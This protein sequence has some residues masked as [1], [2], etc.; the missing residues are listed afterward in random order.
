MYSSI[1]FEVYVTGVIYI[2]S[3]AL[4]HYIVNVWAS[5]FI[6]PVKYIIVRG[7]FYCPIYGLFFE[8]QIS[9]LQERCVHPMEE[10]YYLYFNL[11][12]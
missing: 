9:C 2:V 6:V 8:A 3:D 5:Y 12:Q 11:K 1:I 10:S 7:S 4:S